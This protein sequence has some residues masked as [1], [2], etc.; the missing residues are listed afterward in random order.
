MEISELSQDKG[1]APKMTVSMVRV[2][3]P[4][5]W[6]TKRCS[7]PSPP[8]YQGGNGGSGPPTFEKDSPRNCLEKKC[9]EISTSDCYLML[10][11][12]R[13][14]YIKKNALPLFSK[15]LD[16]GVVM[17]ISL[18]IPPPIPE[19]THFSGTRY[20]PG[21]DTRCWEGAYCGISEKVPTHITTWQN[22]SESND[23][24][25]KIFNQIDYIICFM[26]KKHCFI[27]ARSF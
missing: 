2:Q 20:A 24:N 11:S 27:D 17:K 21:N 18:E 13:T 6:Y 8:G 16:D 14:K 9:N 19:T 23:T 3:P 5:Q 7:R 1:Y 25:V 4:G 26:N 12:L 15:S 10:V 22:T